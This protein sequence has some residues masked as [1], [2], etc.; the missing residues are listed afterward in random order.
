MGRPRVKRSY[1]PRYHASDADIP[2]LRT[3][4]A[5]EK[6]MWLNVHREEVL[7]YLAEHG[8]AETRRHYG[9]TNHSVLEE[10]SKRWDAEAKHKKLSEAGYLRA[11]VAILAEDNSNLRAEI[12]DL[13]EQYGMFRE[14][15]GNQLAEKFFIPLMKA[16]IKLDPQL[17]VFKEPQDP[18]EV[19][20]LMENSKIT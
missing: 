19:K 17:E 8:D 15:V 3:L 12:R 6:A 11:E 5:G 9:L 13:K 16:A 1:T 7:A 20:F 4:R 14:N 18:L 2:E 10:L